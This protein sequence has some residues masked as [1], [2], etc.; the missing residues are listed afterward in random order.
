[1][2]HQLSLYKDLFQI[3]FGQLDHL[4]RGGEEGKPSYSQQRRHFQAGLENEV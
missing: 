1:M 4:K 3:A 2:I